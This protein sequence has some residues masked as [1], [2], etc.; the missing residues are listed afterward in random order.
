MDDG[1]VAFDAEGKIIGDLACLRCGYN[2]RLMR[3]EAFCPEC[4]VGVERTVRGD[5]LRFSDA[6]WLRGVTN[7]LGVLVVTIAATLAIT[8]FSAA[9]FPVSEDR[10]AAATVIELLA[11]GCCAAGAWRFGRPQPDP[12]RPEAALAPRRMV[13]LLA[14]LQMAPLTLQWPN[15]A[16]ANHQ[17]ILVAIVFVNIGF[18]ASI[19]AYARTLAGRAGARREELSAKKLLVGCGLSVAAI[20]FGLAEEGRL[21]PWRT[22]GGAAVAIGLTMFLGVSFATILFLA[23]MRQT[24]DS[25]AGSL[26]PPRRT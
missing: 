21:F 10:P 6:A 5:L 12:L 15:I 26:S 7:G 17:V 22:R 24:L 19:L 16:P 1:A 14:L 8:I 3:P 20:L 25:L 23:G 9:M 2:L 18:V 11:R 4:G 13:R